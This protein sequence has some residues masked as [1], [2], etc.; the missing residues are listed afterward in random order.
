MAHRCEDCEA[1]ATKQVFWTR[2]EGPYHMCDMCAHHS[3]KNRNAIE[4][5]TEPVTV[6]DHTLWFPVPDGGGCIDWDCDF[7]YIVVMSD[8]KIVI[9]QAGLFGSERNLKLKYPNMTQ[10]DIDIAEDDRRLREGARV[11]LNDSWTKFQTDQPELYA[12][13]AKRFNFVEA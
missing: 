1:P 5:V 6:F 7:S 3:V 13:L 11:K 10:A 8:G 4:V 9:E 2:P 12:H